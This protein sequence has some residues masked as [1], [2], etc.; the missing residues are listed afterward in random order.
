MPSPHR[1]S[2]PWFLMFIFI[3]FS[4]LA[5]LSAC[6]HSGAVPE[7]TIPSQT[8]GVEQTAA[9]VVPT[10]ELLPS[11]SPIL[12]QT[13]PSDTA[14]PGW[15][16]VVMSTSTGL[17]VD[18]VESTGQI[19]PTPPRPNKPT[20]SPTPPFANLRIQK[21]GPYSKV[22]SPIQLKAII[23]PGED[24]RVY[25]DLIGED[26]R[27]ITSQWIDFTHSNER[28]VY[29]TPDIPFEIGSLAETARLV[30]Y[31]LDR[32]SRT[33]YQTSVDLILLQMGDSEI[34][35]PLVEQ[36]PYM[37][38]I[39]WE[40]ATVRGG[41]MTVEGQVRLVNDQPLIIELFDEQGNLVGSAEAQIDQPN[42]LQP[43]VPFTMYVPYS[44]PHW[45]PVRLTA[46]QTSATRIPGTVWLSSVKIYLEP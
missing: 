38:S 30:L 4:S 17:P 32:F 5:F 39:P 43:Y 14:V 6:Q 19:S 23:N 36:E 22:T 1:P 28:W 3:G 15:V 29:V 45:T 7:L 26:G 40:G 2:L 33:V 10:V 21:P 11:E 24:K 44:V 9:L 35:V 20:P 46:R 8:A 12:Q 16:T 18:A 37:I 25:I 13:A 27:V 42:E 41:V 34:N 31:T